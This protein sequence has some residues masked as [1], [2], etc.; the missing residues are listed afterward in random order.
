MTP[1]YAAMARRITADWANSSGK[2]T[3]L[4]LG[5]GAGLL[6]VEVKRLY[7]QAQIMGVD[8]SQAMLDL[9][10][11]NAVSS[12]LSGIELK[13]GK[14]EEIPVESES[15]DLLMTQFSLHEWEDLNKGF[16]EITRVLRQNGI[17]VI[18]AWNKSCPSWKF[19]K[20]N[21][22]HMFN[23]GW[24][25]AKEARRSRRRSYPFRAV[26]DLVRRYD[27]A[28]IEMEEDVIL[29]IKA[30]KAPRLLSP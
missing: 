23:Y 28:P 12:G 16:S 4:D 29:F 27:L 22:T 30:R 15:V 7:P 3:F 20:H 6:P 17:L 5:T 25:R 14:A 1:V 2:F 10:Q 8:P 26:M 13:V 11:R 9:A 18:R 21:V 19:L 24:N